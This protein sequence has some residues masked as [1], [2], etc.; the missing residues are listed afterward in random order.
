M[1]ATI[2]QVNT[3]AK[4]NGYIVTAKQGPT[5]ITETAEQAYAWA[6]TLISRDLAPAIAAYS[7]LPGGK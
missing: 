3:E 5:F 2:G 6:L 7:V 4:V 1:E